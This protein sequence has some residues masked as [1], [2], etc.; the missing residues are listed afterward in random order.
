[1]RRVEVLP[2]TSLDY[3]D[4][5]R[6]LSPR[7]RI[8]AFPWA[9]NSVGTIT[10]IRRIAQLAHD[11]GAIAWAD[12]VQYAPHLPMDL[13]ATGADVVLFSAYKFCGPHLGIAYGRRDLAG[14]ARSIASSWA[15]VTPCARR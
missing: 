6:A 1:M 2:D 15:S 11:A 5:A 9:A 13:P 4:P 7:T 3:G 8:V 10:D 12:A 14:E